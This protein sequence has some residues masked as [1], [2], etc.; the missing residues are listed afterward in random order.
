MFGGG[1][2]PPKNYI[3]EKDP[4]QKLHKGKEPPQTLHKGK[5]PHQTL[6][7]RKRT[8]SKIAGSFPSM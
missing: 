6:H 2:F 4:H 5:E 8:P 7:R 3:E 1:S